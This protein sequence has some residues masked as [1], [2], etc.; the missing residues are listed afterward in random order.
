[1]ICGLELISNLLSRC[2]MYE[3][4]F[5]QRFETNGKGLSHN[6]LDLVSEGYKSALKEL[7]IRILKFQARSVCQLSRN[8]VSGGFRSVLKIDDWDSLLEDIR[9]QE[10]SCQTF[11]DSVKDQNALVAREADHRQRTSVLLDKLEELSL[12]VKGIRNTLEEIHISE[13]ESKCFEMLR[14]SNY[15]AR[16]DLNPKRLPGTCEWF[17]DHPKYRGWL[18]HT[19]TSRLL[20]VSANPGCGKSV[21]AKALVDQHD[22]DGVCYY[23][24]KDD[25]TVTRSAA[26]AIC[27][28]LHQICDLRPDLIK[29]VLPMY[30]RNGAKLVDS[31]EDLWSI[32]AKI[33]IDKDFG[34]IIC[35]LD[36]I[37]ECSEDDQ[38]KLL[39]RLATV[40][41]S[42]TSIKILITSRPYKSIEAALFHGTGLDKNEIRLLGEAK[43]E[44][45]M[46]EK[47]ITIFITF[48]IKEFQKLRESCDIFDNVH[49]TLQHHLDGIQNRTYLWVSAVFNELEKEVD[50]PNSFLMDIIKAL[51]DSVDGAYE[52]ILKKS[53]KAKKPILIKLLHIMLAAFRPLSLMEMNMALSIQGTS[54]G[55]RRNGLHPENSFGKWLR[56]L[57]GFFVNIVDN[58]LYFAHQTAREF[59]IQDDGYK[60]AVSTG[61]KRSF[62]LASSHT[63]LAQTCIDYLL[64]LY[65]GSLD[66]TFQS[67]ATSYWPQ[68]CQSLEVDQSLA[69]QVRNFMFQS[70]SVAPSFVRWNTTICDFS[71]NNK[72]WKFGRL[73]DSFGKTDI[74][75]GPAPTPLFLACEFG[76]LSCILELKATPDIDWIKQN[77][78][79]QT[80]LHI[81]V[82]N[83]HPEV[84]K[85]LLTA[86]ADVNIR[87]MSGKTALHPAVLQENIEIVRFLLERGADVNIRYPFD[88]TALHLAVQQGNIEIMKLLL[89]AGADLSIIHILS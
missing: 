7:Y 59:L 18:A 21:L 51:P 2:A 5:H 64:F 67:Y 13:A 56:D 88:Q 33:I 72:P 87:D 11:F 60:S 28:L 20:W 54:S 86:G 68:H 6:E 39:Q 79:G 37:D 44:Q 14:T 70:G 4:A 76:W 61:W 69:N 85:L 46:I 27:A 47:E 73:S 1:M 42:S 35:I 45:S 84:A 71:E 12:G 34:N 17:W 75:I 74:S 40:A 16:K 36:A 81:A 25:D 31:F 43:P 19:S 78:Y 26:H 53:T 32:F 41:T 23:F 29:H 62:Q 63:L 83:N 89:T 82:Q 3:S 49:E 38:K 57:C 65:D 24:F 10:A 58:H 48:K 22:H 80:G 66:D 15:V 77:M 8:V 30:K 55:L 9:L 50:A 52:N